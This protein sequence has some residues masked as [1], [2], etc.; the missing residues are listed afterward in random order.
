MGR[1]RG[2]AIMRRGL[3]GA[4][5]VWAFLAIGGATCRAAVA[6]TTNGTTLVGDVTLMKGAFNIGGSNLT[7]DQ[8]ARL[9]FLARPAPPPPKAGSPGTVVASPRLPG[10]TV[11]SV[12]D[13]PKEIPRQAQFADNAKVRFSDN[14]QDPIIPLDGVA[15]LVFQLPAA[16]GLAAIPAGRPG[17]LLRQDNLFLEGEFKGL[18]TGKVKMSSVLFGLKE[19]YLGDVAMVILRD[20]RLAPCQ[21]EILTRDRWRILTDS[22]RVETDGIVLEHAG[23]SGM[24]LPL[25]SLTEIRRSREQP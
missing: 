12:P 23:L 8:L 9:D 20:V 16:R 18:A 21:F 5:A 7:P 19:Y 22:F 10:E 15:R 24:K 2:M 1:V 4:V 14:P 11:L 6:Q 3:V 17:V 13:Q 25:G